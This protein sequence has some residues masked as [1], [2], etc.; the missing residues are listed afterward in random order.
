[1]GQAVIVRS[2]DQKVAG[3]KNS[4]VL[5][6]PFCNKVFN[7]DYLLYRVGGNG[8]SLDLTLKEYK[9]YVVQHKNETDE[10]RKNSVNQIDDQEIIA[11]NKSEINMICLQSEIDRAI[12]EKNDDKKLDEAEIAELVKIKLQDIV[13]ELVGDS[14]PMNDPDFELEAE[15]EGEQELN[16]TLDDDQ[17]VDWRLELNDALNVVRERGRFDG[18]RLAERIAATFY[19]V[20]GVEASLD[21][22]SDT[23]NRIK[24]ELADE[25]IDDLSSGQFKGYKVA[26]KLASKMKKASA[27]ELV[28]Y[29]TKIVVANIVGQGRADFVASNGRSPTKQE[30]RQ[31]VKKFAL[32]LAEKGI[33]DEIEDEL[34]SNDDSD[35][36]PNNKSDSFLAQVDKL[37]D[38]QFEAEQNEKYEQTEKL[39]IEQGKSTKNAEGY[40]LWFGAGKESNLFKAIE[41]FKM[42][43]RREPTNLEVARLKDFVSLNVSSKKKEDEEKKYAAR[44]NVYFGQTADSKDFT[45]E[46]ATKWFER[47]N[48]RKPTDSELGGIRQ[49]IEADKSQLIECEYEVNDD[50]KECDDNETINGFQIK[51]HNVVQKKRAT[52]YTLD[53][54]DDDKQ[55]GDEKLA[56][57]W[58]K[59]FNNRDPTKQEQERINQFIRDDQMVDID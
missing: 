19:E 40:N 33:R 29:A 53:F 16:G 49:F 18:Q 6:A 24:S 14:N 36:D 56:V 37:E 50:E 39:W 21:Q 44:Y 25:A 31:N 32:E 1:M 58:F 8:D 7:G 34:S 2:L 59:R 11:L 10:A 3:K 15:L 47:F 55:K 35:Y 45:L 26:K 51:Y 12:R 42:R 38:D 46:K 52:K 22:L 23:L 9:E 43:N 27:V 4:N 20:N 30:L 57:Q 54:D 41:S 17:N 13:D 48:G 5:P 28:D